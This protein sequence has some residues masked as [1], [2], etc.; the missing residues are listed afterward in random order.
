MI[1]ASATQFHVERPWGQRPVITNLRIAFVWS[2]RGDPATHCLP[3]PRLRGYS[4]WWQSQWPASQ[5]RQPTIIRHHG[6][7]HTSGDHSHAASEQWR[8]WCMITMML[9]RWCNDHND[10][11]DAMIMIIVMLMWWCTDHSDAGEMMQWSY[12]VVSMM[13]WWCCWWD[14]AWSQWCWWCRITMMQMRWC[15][16]QSEADCIVILMRWCCCWWD[17]A[18]WQWC[19]GCSPLPPVCQERQKGMKMKPTQR[20]KKRDVSGVEGGVS[21]SAARFCAGSTLP[22][23]QCVVCVYLVWG[24]IDSIMKSE[25]SYLCLCLLTRTTQMCPP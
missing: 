10:E 4:V 7:Q 21:V 12:C 19:W 5:H 22:S 16:D 11:D 9:V 18:W 25:C 14:G 13:R 6:R 23:I 17:D 2:T 24:V 15:N 1:F 3:C 8:W 20:H